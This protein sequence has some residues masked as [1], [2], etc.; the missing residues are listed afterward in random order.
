MLPVKWN[1]PRFIQSLILLSFSVYLYKLT[2]FDYIYRLVSTNIAL[3]VKVMWYVVCT[4]P[5]YTI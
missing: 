2:H 4:L 5:S 3:L 1:A